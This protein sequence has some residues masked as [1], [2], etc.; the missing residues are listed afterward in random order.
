[1]KAKSCFFLVMLFLPWGLSAMGLPE[2]TPL[3]PDLKRGMSAL[4]QIEDEALRKANPDLD[5]Q[6][7]YRAHYLGLMDRLGGDALASLTGAE[8]KYYE[9]FWNFTRHQILSAL[10]QDR[11]AL[12]ALE[13]ARTL[14]LELWEGK[15]IV[16]A[17]LLR[18]LGDIHSRL[19]PYKGPMSTIALSNES[20]RYL[21]T[22]LQLDAKNSRALI[23][24]GVWYL[25]APP[26]AG[27][28][29]NVSRKSLELAYEY[30]TDYERFLA[31]TWQ[32]F[33]NSRAM[34][35]N[36]ARRALAQAKALAPGNNWLQEIE[37]KLEQGLDLVSAYEAQ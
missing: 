1:M 15:V 21:E 30:G 34:D 32:V 31:S 29:L 26:I 23:G 36:A 27:G 8:A 12:A 4:V 25:F 9:A 6:E 19:I 7:A 33:L 37:E 3:S 5:G 13:K 17:E 35:R 10:D 28:D 24:L 11:E 22:A 18:L 2:P 16:Q 14:A 20:K